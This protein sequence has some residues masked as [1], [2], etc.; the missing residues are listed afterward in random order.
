MSA[1]ETTEDGGE[2]YFA[3]VSDL[4]V[5]ILFVF[6]LMLTVFALNFRDAEDEQKVARKQYEEL[7]L[8]AAAAEKKAQEE[9]ERA[10]MQRQKNEHLRGL[11][12]QAVERMTQDIEDRQ[13]ARQRLLSRLEDML[14]KA[15]VI[16]TVDPETGVLRLPEQILFERGQSTLGTGTN[17]ARLTDARA[18]LDKLSESLASVLPCYSSRDLRAGC[19]E[20]DLATLEGVLVEGHSDVQGY[21]GLSPEDSRDRNDRL[22]VERSLNVF[23]E[24]RQ[25]NGLDDLK[26]TSGFPLL[27]VSAYGDRR[28]IVAGSTEEEF[29]KNRRI[30]LRFLLST[31]TSKE[32]QRLIDEI[33]PA[34]ED[35]Q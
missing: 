11:L 20:R 16:V 19:Q 34:L 5:G 29:Q 15:G 13:Q 25:K 6:L 26:N 35:V 24:I 33:K 23:K 10:E 1:T 21:R 14:K 2:G 4:M 8:R 30:D 18:V 3:S 31:K 28:P 17:N 27:A 22:S 12:K 32:L 7:L 9:A